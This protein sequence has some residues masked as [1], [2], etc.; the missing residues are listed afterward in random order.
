MVSSIFLPQL[1]ILYMLF[2]ATDCLKLRKNLLN[3]EVFKHLPQ[4]EAFVHLT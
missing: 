2:K 4:I 3:V 1:L